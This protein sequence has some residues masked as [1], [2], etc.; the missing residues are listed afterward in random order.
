[1]HYV[2]ARDFIYKNA[3]PIDMARWKY[4]FENGSKEAVLEALSTY[5][6]EDGGF[7]HALDLIVGILI[8]H[9]FKHG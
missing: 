6:N 7:A 3:R 8:H 2:K 5:Q 9:Q 1:M 4:L